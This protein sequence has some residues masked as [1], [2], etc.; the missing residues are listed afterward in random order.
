M[1]QVLIKY[2]KKEHL[3]QL[4][5]GSIRFSPS[6]IYIKQEEKTH[7]K[8]QGDL[9]EGKLKIRIQGAE[10]RSIA[11]GQVIGY[12]PE[13]SIVIVSV[14]DVNNMPVF[15]LSKYSEDD[16]TEEMDDEAVFTL[17]ISAEKLD[18]IQS[19]FP[20]ATHALI[21]IEP[22]KFI[23]E[24]TKIPGHTFVCGDIHYYDYDTNSVEMLMYLAK[25]NENLITNTELP[26]TIENQYRLLFC[27]DKSFAKQSEFR[28]VELT[29]LIT[30]PT[31]YNFSFT[32]KYLIIP[33]ERLRAPVSLKNRTNSTRSN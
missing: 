1:A 21:I 12:L 8:G 7:N 10:K 18:T 14:E 5:N 11:T 31:K 6:Q 26:I 29:E 16:I 20:D 15:C 32:S 9:L 24:I 4:V 19:D 33:I 25:G 27:K 3:E 30:D 22:E 23:S 13:G 28:F 2:G 17:S